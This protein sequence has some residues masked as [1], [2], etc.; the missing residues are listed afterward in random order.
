MQ[1]IKEIEAEIKMMDRIMKPTLWLPLWQ[2]RIIHDA[3]L[4][5]FIGEEKLNEAIEIIKI[6]E[7]EDELFQFYYGEESGLGVSLANASQI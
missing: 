4:Y 6:F 1:D 2:Q 7:S 5:G 3:I